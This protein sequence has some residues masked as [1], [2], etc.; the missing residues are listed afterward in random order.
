MVLVLLVK[1]KLLDIYSDDSTNDQSRAVWQRQA[2]TN[3]AHTGG[4]RMMMRSESLGV[5]VSIYME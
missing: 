2:A 3:R 5:Q 1:K 4:E